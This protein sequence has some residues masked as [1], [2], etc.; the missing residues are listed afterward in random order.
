MKKFIIVLGI[1]AISAVVFVKLNEKEPLDTGVRD[2]ILSTNSSG[3]K[4]IYFRNCPSTVQGYSGLLIAK[5][6]QSGRTS[7]VGKPGATTLSQIQS[8]LR[9]SSDNA[10]SYRDEELSKDVDVQLT[11]TNKSSSDIEYD[12]KEGDYSLNLTDDQFVYLK[13]SLDSSEHVIDLTIFADKVSRDILGYD[14]PALNELCSSGAGQYTAMF[15]GLQEN[16]MRAKI[17]VL[18]INP[19][20]LKPRMH[21]FSSD[22]DGRDIRYI[23]AQ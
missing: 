8:S 4:Q 9:W 1:V 14:L 16:G 5:N 17:L 7:I 18:T 2:T 13:N 23:G 12:E 11:V 15:G 19:S 21:M 6:V 20:T 10:F 3:T 22:L